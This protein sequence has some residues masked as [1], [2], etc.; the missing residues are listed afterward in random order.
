MGVIDTRG[1][2]PMLLER[3][4][5]IRLLALD[6]DGILTDGQLYFDNRGNEMKSFSTRDGLGIRLL[7]VQGIETALI[8]ARNSKIVSKRAENL[9]IRRVYQGSLNKLEAFHDLLSATGLAPDQVCYA[10]DDWL[11]LP[12]L[13]RAGLSVTVSDG[14]PVVKKRVHWVTN[15]SG[16]RGAVREVCDLILA[17]QGLDGK[18]LDGILQQ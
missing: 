15:R 1:F 11:D 18:A 4:A 14:D 3:A 12:I 17:A 5:R 7:A 10:G 16:G 9:G 8:T 6:V 13:E 2:D